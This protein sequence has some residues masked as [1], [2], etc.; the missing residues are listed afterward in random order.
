MIRFWV[1]QQV[2][3]SGFNHN[4]LKA[5][6]PNKLDAANAVLTVTSETLDGKVYNVY[7]MPVIRFVGGFDR[8]T[9]W[10]GFWVYVPE[11]SEQTIGVELM[12]GGQAHLPGEYQ[13]YPGSSA[14][15]AGYS[16]TIQDRVV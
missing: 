14:L 11:G 15:A 10:G 7:S 4:L 16:Q 12:D 13:A 8:P 1:P 2:V 9:S 6:K 3:V 5:L